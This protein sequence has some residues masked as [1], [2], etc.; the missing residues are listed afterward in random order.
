MIILVLSLFLV[1]SL[2]A[3]S[4]ACGSDFIEMIVADSSD[5]Y[6]SDATIE[7][8]ADYPYDKYDEKHRSEMT[9]I[10]FKLSPQEAEEIAKQPLKLSRTDDFCGNPLRQRPGAASIKTLKQRPASM[11]LGFCTQEGFYTNIFLL[12]VSAPG[13]VTDYYV[14][15]FLGGCHQVYKFTLTKTG[16]GRTSVQ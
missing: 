6:I 4:Q 2:H 3:H 9:R 15:P 14:A 13:Y 12:K 7:L 5:K 16:S 11:N 10:A 8:I 1:P